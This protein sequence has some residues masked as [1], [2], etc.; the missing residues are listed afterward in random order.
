MENTID[1]SRTVYELVQEHPDLREILYDLGFREIARDAVLNSLGRTMTIPGGARLRN[2]PMS[3]ILS[4]LHQVG[5]RTSLDEQTAGSEQPDPE[6]TEPGTAISRREQLKGYL[7]RLKDHED[8]ETV[9]Q[10]FAA[11]FMDVE[12]SE[13]MEAEQE[14]MQE[15]TPPEEIRNLCDLHSALFHG[16]TREERIARAEQAVTDSMDG[17][18]QEDSRVSAASALKAVTGHPLQVLSEEN[19]RLEALIQEYRKTHNDSLLASLR[20]LSIHYAKKGDLLYPLLSVKHQIS[21]PS[22]VMWTVDDEIRDTLNRLVRTADHSPVWSRD[23]DSTLQRALEM[24]YKEENI[25]FPLC[26]ETFTTDDWH[27]V[28]RDSMDYD[29]C[30]GVSW[31]DWPEAREALEKEA[32]DPGSNDDE[33]IRLGGGSLTL[34]ELQSLLR[35]MPL[36]ITFVDADNINRFFNEG[37]K[38]FKRPEMALGRE[39]FTCHPPRVQPMVRQIL[40]EFRAG[41]RDEVSIWMEKGGKPFLVRY[42]AV[43]D[44][45]GTYLGTME[46]VQDMQSARDHFLEESGSQSL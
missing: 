35:V 31:Q 38:V 3:R 45:Q 9:R 4:A 18:S 33:R 11:A 2:I 36:E 6:S 22:Q 23:L 37:P 10:D 26:A 7:K 44:P 27:Q 42:L 28:W 20:E 14:L 24:I 8:L 39:V 21:G 41:T 43:R 1:F 46:L 12:A 5:Y 25:L 32:A 17:H 16:Q 34:S 19:R 30:L 29:P 40:K 15:G 13:I